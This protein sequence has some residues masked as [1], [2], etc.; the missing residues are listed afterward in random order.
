MCVVV[1]KVLL[2][3]QIT[4]PPLPVALE[5]SM[6]FALQDDSCEQAY[7]DCQKCV[8]T[9]S[10][11]GV[12]LHILRLAGQHQADPTVGPNQGVGR[13]NVGLVVFWK[14]NLFFGFGTR[15]SP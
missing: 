1:G 12:S 13:E 7:S 8:Y 5:R 11:D 10:F 4:T 6:K 15:S 3:V 14:E 2:R 9:C